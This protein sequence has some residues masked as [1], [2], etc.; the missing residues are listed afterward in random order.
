MAAPVGK[1]ERS[2]E[3]VQPDAEQ[4]GEEGVNFSH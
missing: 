2:E 3:A 1:L 4:A